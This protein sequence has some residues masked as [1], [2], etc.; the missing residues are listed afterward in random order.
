[1]KTII[2]FELKTRTSYFYLT[3]YLKKVYKFQ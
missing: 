3:Y 2:S 1:M